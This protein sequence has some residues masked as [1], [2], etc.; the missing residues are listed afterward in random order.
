MK[1]IFTLFIAGLMLT[2]LAI[3]P[4]YAE[5]MSGMRVYTL[6][7]FDWDPTGEQAGTTVSGVSGVGG[8]S[9]YFTW[10]AGDT[11]ALTA[12]NTLINIDQISS[13]W[14]RATFMVD[15]GGV[16]TVSDQGSTG[17]TWFVV[18]ELYHSLTAAGVTPYGSV[19]AFDIDKGVAYGIGGA[20]TFVITMPGGSDPSGATR[21]PI[22]IT[23]QLQTATAKYIRFR[24]CSGS[25][26]FYGS[27]TGTSAAN[28]VGP[29]ALFILKP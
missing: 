26:Q 16:T 21:A 22:D 10:T 29:K 4:A 23:T 1:K 12:D 18:A 7:M 5:L 19:P 25:S 14:T 3:A 17:S 8:A 27:P 24:F 13:D 20:S 6:G 2:C 28:D 15:A 11:K 9:R